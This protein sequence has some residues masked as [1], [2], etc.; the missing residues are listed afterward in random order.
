MA[1]TTYKI[2]CLICGKEFTTGYPTQKVCSAKKS[3]ECWYKYNAK[4]TIERRKK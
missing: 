2:K 1:A 3:Y 4:K